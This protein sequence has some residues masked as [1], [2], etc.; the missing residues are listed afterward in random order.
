MSFL[1]DT[2]V[3][4]WWFDA[5]PRLPASYEHLI[6]DP[7]PEDPFW[8]SD[9]SLWEIAM[10]VQLGRVRL[11]MPLRE[12]LEAATAPPLVRRIGISPAVAAEVAALPDTFHRDPADRILVATARVLGATFL[13]QDRRIIDSGIVP[14]FS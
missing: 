13:T 1:I 10:L 9:I 3:L 8:V 4:V 7:N 6:R 5:S 2:H 14:V 12:W 11:R